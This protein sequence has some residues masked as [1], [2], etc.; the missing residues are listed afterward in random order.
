MEMLFPI[1]PALIL[2]VYLAIVIYFVLLAT[3]LVNA[4]ERIAGALEQRN[5]PGAQPP[6][7]G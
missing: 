5:A 7:G 1:V 4:A 6:L 3:R 2:L